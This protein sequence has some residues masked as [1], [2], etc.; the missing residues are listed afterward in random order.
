MFALD[1]AKRQEPNVFVRFIN[2]AVHRPLFLYE[3]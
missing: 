1:K 2:Q 3:T